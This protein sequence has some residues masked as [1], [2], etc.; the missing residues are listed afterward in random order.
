[1]KAA[2]FALVL[3]FC[4]LGM[5]ALG[6]SFGFDASGILSIPDQ[7]KPQT[8]AIEPAQVDK[9]AMTAARPVMET[10]AGFRGPTG[11]PSVR[12][13]AGPPPQE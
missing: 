9:P 11:Q 8:S 2:T 10:P 1:M 3:A 6:S 13:P 5:L 4:I 12:G 7:A